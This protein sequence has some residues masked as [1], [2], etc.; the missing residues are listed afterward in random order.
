MGM[1]AGYSNQN[2]NNN[3]FFGN[4]AGTYSTASNNTWIGV[5]GLRFGPFDRHVV[6]HTLHAINIFH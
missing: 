4:Q 1:W 2:G 3:S 5:L 6:D